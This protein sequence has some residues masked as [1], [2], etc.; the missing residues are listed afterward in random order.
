MQRYVAFLRGINLGG[1]RPAMARLRELFEEV[2]LSNVA[3]FIASGNVVFDADDATAADLEARIEAHLEASL[4][5]A[6]DT[7]IRRLDALHAIAGLDAL[8]PAE[9]SEWNAHVI[10]LRDDAGDDV[11]AAL[12]RLET[13]GDRF[14]VRG[15]E[16]YWLRRGRLSDSGIDATA[17]AKALGGPSNTMRNLN[18]VRRIIAKFQPDR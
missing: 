6:V 8:P 15:R 11:T 7:F 14:I 2:G 1:R 17:L 12:H 3:T 9:D 5:Y 13:D 10:F 16:V 4:G 18:T